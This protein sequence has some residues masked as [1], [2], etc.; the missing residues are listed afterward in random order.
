MVGHNA[1]EVIHEAAMAMKYRAPIPDFIDLLHVFPAMSEA[2]KI[3]AI[4]KVQ[5]PRETV[6]LRGVGSSRSNDAKSRHRCVP[7]AFRFGESVPAIVPVT[8]QN[9]VS[10]ANASQLARSGK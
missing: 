4:S 5:E 10:R 7:Q 9:H 8:R 6:L 2:L 3:V 1:R